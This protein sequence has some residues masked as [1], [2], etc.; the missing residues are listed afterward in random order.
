MSDVGISHFLTNHVN[1][2]VFPLLTHL[3]FQYAIWAKL[4][5]Y[6]P[7]HSF[8][9]QQKR[10]H[11]FLVIVT[12]FLHWAHMRMG[13]FWRSLNYPEDTFCKCLQLFSASSHITLGLIFTHK[14]LWFPR[15]QMSL[16]PSRHVYEFICPTIIRFQQISRLFSF[17]R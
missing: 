13:S 8:V 17:I 9:S 10:D 6:R 4:G 14:V 12:C 16:L 3:N 11:A 7:H 5:G 1:T 2:T 15:T